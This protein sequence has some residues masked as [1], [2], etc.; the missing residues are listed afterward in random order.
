MISIVIVNY[1]TDQKTLG[2]I[3]TLASQPEEFRLILVDNGANEVGKIEEYLRREFPKPYV[4][5][6][7]GHNLGFG[8]AVNLGAKKA[9]SLKDDWIMLLNTDLSIPDDYMAQVNRLLTSQGDNFRIFG[10]P[11]REG[12]R[13]AYAGRIRWLRHTLPHVYSKEEV[14]KGDYAIGGAMIIGS[15]V[16]ESIGMFDENYFMYFEDADF[17]LRASRNKVAI[18]FPDLTPVTHEVMGSSKKNSPLLLRWHYR[19]SLYFNFTHGHIVIKIFSFLWSIFSA[20]KQVIKISI[21]KN[22]DQSRAILSGV[23][24]FYQR[25]MGK[26][27]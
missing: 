7:P 24:D 5:Y 8:A 15:K 22:K 18:I 26:V 10:L 27:S 16:F 19:N 23:L 6:N 17:S 25:R 3:K 9:M 13:V 21:G 14:K 4:Y 20:L 1:F 2:L 12:G 11:L